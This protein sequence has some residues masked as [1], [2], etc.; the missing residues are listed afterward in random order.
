LKRG[1]L[2][3]IVNQYKGAVTRWCRQNR[4]DFAWRPRYYD[5]IIRNEDELQR[6]REYIANNPLK[7]SLDKESLPETRCIASLQSHHD[8]H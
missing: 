1:S 3:S 4:H 6:I 7:W 5:H 2:Q 8:Q